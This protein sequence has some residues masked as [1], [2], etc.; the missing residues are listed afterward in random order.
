MDK[1]LGI[2][3]SAAP[4]MD[5]ECELVGQ[6][7][8]GMTQSV[9]W[10]IK[11]TPAPPEGEA[12]DLERLRASQFYLILLGTDIVAPM[13]VEHAEARRREL[14]IF[15][16]RNVELASSPAATYFARNLGIT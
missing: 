9:R 12:P 2:Y 6:L 10:T 11:R 15:A 7:L 4:E 13:G 8:A 5:A 1:E 16:Y 14:A 3:I